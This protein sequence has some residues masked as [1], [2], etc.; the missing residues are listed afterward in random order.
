L[1]DNSIILESN[2]YLIQNY[3]RHPIRIVKG[4][5]SWVLDS[6]GKKYL[7]FTTGIAV[8]NLG[9]NN[10]KI[11]S[12]I[13]KQIKKLVHI[14]NLFVIE[15]QVKFAKE[16]IKSK[17]GYKVFFCNSGTEA[18]EAAFKL[19][20]KWGI[21]NGGKNVI[22][23][24]TGAFHGRTFG[25]LSATSPKKYREGFYPLVPGFKSVEFNNIKKLKETVRKN[26][27]IVAIILEPIQGEAGVKFPDPEYLKKVEVVCKENNILLILDEIQVGLGRTGKIYCH[28]HYDL[29]PDI[30][31]LAKGLGG[32][33]PCGAIIANPK[34]ADFLTPSSHGTT[35]GGNPLAMSAGI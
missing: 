31:S 29:S 34:I 12:S 22:I 26:K 24:A 35:M 33:I 14:S 1:K 11:N 15:E 23:F 18:N 32:G 19:A 21:F 2:R 3:Q 25:S 17:P 7:D 13:E 6:K 16:L 10:S 5:G 30:I 28:Q 4:S 9:H 27:K 20:R 8:N